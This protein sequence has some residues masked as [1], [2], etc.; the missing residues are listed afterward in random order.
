MHKDDKS[1]IY[2]IEHIKTNKKYIGQS[3]H[4]NERWYKHRNELNNGSHY[5]DYLQKAWNKHG[6]ENFIFYVLEYC[7]VEELDEK[8]ICYI[9]MYN[10][11][12][13]NYGYNLKSGGQSTNVVYS[14]EMKQKLSKS[15]KKT[16]SNSN[17]KKIRSIAALKQWANPEI[18]Q[19]I[20]G[21]NNGMYGKHHTEE[22]KRKM[23]EAQ[24]GKKIKQKKYYPHILRRIKSKI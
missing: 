18:K 22:S 15:I 6:E 14:E 2:C 24:K 3:I 21:K 11:M 1:G 5:N 23:S 9:D 8:E 13:R 4:I 17:L 20:M 7:P 12:N 19:K 16:Y 10:T